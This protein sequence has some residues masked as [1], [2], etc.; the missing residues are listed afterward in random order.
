[1][2]IRTLV[3]DAFSMTRMMPS[4]PVWLVGGEEGS[5]VCVTVLA[6]TNL[7]GPRSIHPSRWGRFDI[8]S[9]PAE[10]TSLTLKVVCF[11]VGEDNASQQCSQ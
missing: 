3:S 8:Y 2:V 1:M 11:A 6:L 4:R 7:L 9:T 10:S 5:G